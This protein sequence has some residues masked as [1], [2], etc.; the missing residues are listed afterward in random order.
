MSKRGRNIP[1]PNRCSFGAIKEKRPVQLTDADGKKYT[2]LVEYDMDCPQCG[3]AGSI[4]VP[5]DDER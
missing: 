3:G 4:H 2:K 5:G 1:C